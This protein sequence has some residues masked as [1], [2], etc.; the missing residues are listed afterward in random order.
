MRCLKNQPDSKQR[1]EKGM[2]DSPCNSSVSSLVLLSF[3]V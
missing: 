1:V 3:S 2:E